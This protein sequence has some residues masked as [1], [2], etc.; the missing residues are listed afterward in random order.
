[1]KNRI[2]VPA[3][4]SAAMLS[5]PVLAA[6]TSHRSEPSGTS[7]V[8]LDAVTTA[9]RCQILQQQLDEA[10]MTREEPTRANEANAMW[11]EGGNVCTSGEQTEGVDHDA[12]DFRQ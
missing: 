9:E 5:A 7:H 4:L 10:I 12:C 8:R 1:M 3:V 11:P 6:T 2:I